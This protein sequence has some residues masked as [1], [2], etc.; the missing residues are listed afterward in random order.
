MLCIKL[1]L[2]AVHSEDTL[3]TATSQIE[4]IVLYIIKI[5]TVIGRFIF[6]LTNIIEITDIFNTFI[7]QSMYILGKIVRFYN[8]TITIYNIHH[9]NNIARIGSL[10]VTPHLY[11]CTNCHI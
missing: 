11:Y 4:A 8:I 2:F 7:N 6:K 10:P 3:N 5:K 1:F 9:W